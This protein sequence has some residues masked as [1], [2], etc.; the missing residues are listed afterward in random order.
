MMSVQ[1]FITC[2][3]S[4]EFSKQDIDVQLKAG[5]I[6]WFCKNTSL[7]KKTA[8]MGNIIKY[9]K[10]NGK[11]KLLEWYVCFKNSCP[12][13]GP[14]YDDFRFGRLDKGD[15]QLIIQIDCCW[16]NHRYCVWGR[17]SEDERFEHESPLFETNSKK[18][19]IKWL[20]MPW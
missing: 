19:L 12:L 20:N 4:G 11:V 16:N 8:K 7:Y 3:L 10:D 17:T 9:I 6:D 5:W 18:E 13:N 15:I 14:L 1:A 2:F